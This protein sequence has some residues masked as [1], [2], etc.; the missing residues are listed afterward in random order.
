MA[1]PTDATLPL[2]R[3][4]HVYTLIDPETALVMYVGQSRDVRARLNG[5]L[6]AAR[7]WRRELATI[8]R[9]PSPQLAF[10]GARGRGHR[11]TTRPPLIPLEL[12]H[13]LNRCLDERRR[14]RLAVVETIRCTRDCGCP[15]VN[16]CRRATA[17]ESAWIDT[18]CCAGHPLLNRML[19]TQPPAADQLAVLGT[20]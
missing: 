13:W 6:A 2:A 18:L 11:F 5:H 3:G 17:R 12:A 8:D 19:P 7:A 9:T 10:V 1:A 4:A 14:P 20:I 16:E 15:F